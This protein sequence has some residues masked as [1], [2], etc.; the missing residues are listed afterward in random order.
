[1][2][3]N[4]TE[5]EKASI[6][7]VEIPIQC[8]LMKQTGAKGFTVPHYHDYVEI[9]YG[10]TGNAKIWL[11]G[12]IMVLSPK[13]MIVIN[14]RTAHTVSTYNGQESTYIVIK[15][16]PQVLYAAQQSVFE[17]KYVVPFMMD[18]NIYTDFFDENTLSTT[19]IPDIM[20]K[21]YKEWE[22]RAYGYEIALRISVL[23]ISLWLVR[24]WHGE[25]ENEI[26]EFDLDN[27]LM[28]AISRAMEY[29]QKNYSTATASLAAEAAELSYSYFSRVFKKTMN[30]SFNE[31]LNYIRISEAKK[32]L[33]CT[34]ADIT[35]IAMDTGFATSSYFIEKFRKQDGITPKKFRDIYRKSS[36][37]SV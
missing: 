37:H 15:Y 29:A 8:I 9:L 17:F 22:S 20:Q 33:I 26:P 11:N 16:M 12:K 23:K 7:G 3:T 31:Y 27:N 36:G 1:M 2:N 18:N 24:Y 32:M 5:E 19:E 14:S 10:L 4:W 30:K 6:D 35:Q 34:N 21:I 13:T 25:L 28:V